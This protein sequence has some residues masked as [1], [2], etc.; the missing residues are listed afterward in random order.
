M[1]FERIEVL[2]RVKSISVQRF[3]NWLSKHLSQDKV[4]ICN[5][6]KYLEVGALAPKKCGCYTVCNK[7]RQKCSKARNISTSR[8]AI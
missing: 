2:V 3:K 8:H 1:V 5:R 6:E 4:R 7:A